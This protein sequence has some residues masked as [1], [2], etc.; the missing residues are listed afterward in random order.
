MKS[1][2]QHKP[3]AFRKLNVK[4]VANKSLVKVLDEENNFFFLPYLTHLEG[5]SSLKYLGRAAKG[6]A[7]SEREVLFIDLLSRSQEQNMQLCTFFSS[8]YGPFCL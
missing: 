7:T 2:G 8:L 4:P 1:S 3:Q 5:H 6:N